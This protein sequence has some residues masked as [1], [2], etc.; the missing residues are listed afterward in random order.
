VMYLWYIAEGG[1]MVYTVW[2]IYHANY[3]IIYAIKVG[4]EVCM[5]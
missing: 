5:D 3:D 2:G 1:T 4:K